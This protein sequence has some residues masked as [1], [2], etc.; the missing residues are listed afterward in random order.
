MP[1]MNVPRHAAALL[2]TAAAQAQTTY[3]VDDTPGPGVQ[4]TDLP[5]AV[6]AAASGDTLLVRDGTY[7]GFQV[8]GKA[9]T[10]RHEGSGSVTVGAITIELVPPGEDFALSH[11]SI[12]VQS[13]G[14]AAALHVDSPGATV[15]LLDCICS[16][17][18]FARPALVLA[19]GSIMQAHRSSFRAGDISSA[20]WSWGSV[21]ASIGAGAVLSATACDFQGGS[22]SYHYAAAMSQGGP[23]IASQG[24]VDLREVQVTGGSAAVAG[25]NGSPG[26]GG[27]GVYVFSGALRIAGASSVVGGVG[28]GGL[29]GS[30][31]SPAVAVHSGD[32]TVHPNVSVLPNGAASTA[33]AVQF[34][35]RALPR[36]AIDG[37]ANPNAELDATQPVTIH[38]DH[39]APGAPLFFAASLAP[40]HQLLGPVAV[41]DLFVDI[42]N[43]GGAITTGVLDPNG[44]FQASLLPAVTLAPL[45]SLPIYTQ[46]ASLDAGSMQVLT[47]NPVVR[48]FSL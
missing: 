11:V 30:T 21:G 19:G 38:V 7:S 40:S 36:L 9:L 4:F 31:I 42:A 3:L 34:D 29:G 1:D 35:P 33:G 2:L 25:G 23:G 27:A 15:T 44:S 6:A 32:A 37:T 28:T 24:I 39:G 26:Y 14:A 47:T 16:G 5:A 22:A 43:N 45:L 10:L 12:N 13:A 41:G 8:S 48:T 20:P 18:P 46:A 17:T